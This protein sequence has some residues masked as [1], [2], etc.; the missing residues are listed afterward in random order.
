MHVAAALRRAPRALALLLL[1]PAAARAQAGEPLSLEAATR[2]ALAGSPEVQHAGASRARARADGADGWGAMLPRLS[3]GSGLSRTDVLQRTA[4]DPLTGGIVHLPDSLVK[5]R[6]GFGTSAV[7]SLDWTLF[8]G[9]RNLARTS[10]ARSRGRAA[11]HEMDAAR[12]RVAAEAALAYL[13]ALEAEALVEVRRAQEAHAVELERTAAGRYETGQVPEIDLLQA[14]LAASEAAIAVLDAAAEARVRRLALLA[15]VGLP[16]DRVYL[17][18]PP[19]PVAPL[20][21]A[22]L[23]ARL[24]ATTP[25]LARLRAEREAAGRERRAGELGSLLPT[26]AVGM[27]RVWSEWGQSREAFTLEPRNTQAFYRLSLSW[28]PLQRPG[29]M[30]AERR[31]GTAALLAAEA[32]TRA[33]ELRLRHEVAAGM[34]RWAR[35][36]AVATRARL[37]LALAERQREQAEERYRLGLAPLSERLNAMALWSEAARQD[38]LA[39]Y[40]PLRA[41][42]ELERAT[43]VALRP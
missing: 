9:G 25:V 37:N 43:G 12:V 34:E 18:E 6:R 3:L 17:L 23:A 11:E 20:D 2:A 41:V 13:E 35:A 24:L 27:D 33:A 26:V 10:A 32:D 21:T 5:A 40:A 19:P 39:R 1:L 38:V 36:G 7:A 22:A 16:D 29:A 31:R 4:T 28:S 30:L 15:R 42:A 14:R 8:S